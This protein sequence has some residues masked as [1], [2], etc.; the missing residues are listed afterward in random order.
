MWLYDGN[1]RYYSSETRKYLTYTNPKP[2]TPK[3]ATERELSALRTSLAIGHLLNRVVI[4]PRF[5][6]R[7]LDC[8]LN[9]IIHIKTFDAR[10]SGR[11]R[12]SSF[13]QHPKVPDSVKEGV[14]DGHDIR[15]MNRLEMMR[16]FG[17]MSAKVLNLGNLQ[18]VKV[19]L[20]DRSLDR[21]LSSKLR[22]AFRRARYRQLR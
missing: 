1:D 16:M 6:C 20:D 13:L 21:E 7:N 15:N 18:R 10:F 12:E 5:H 4:L 8:P 9:S 11:Y 22:T 14:A 2:T 17:E 3:N 19:D